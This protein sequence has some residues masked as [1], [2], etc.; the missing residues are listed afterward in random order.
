M[1]PSPPRRRLLQTGLALGAS[2]ALPRARACEFFTTSLRIT[3]PW[4]RA[5]A[6]ADRFAIVNMKFDEVTRTDRLIGV[7]TPVAE[8][9]DM[10]GLLARPTVDFVIPQGQDSA[11][12][13][14]GTFLRLVGLKFPLLP[15]RE[16]P[17]RLVFEQ[18]GAVATTL[19]V[20]YARF[21]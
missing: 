16:F 1:T 11:L 21:K 5:S 12:S 17:L 13:E 3:H 9:A 2:L 7:E 8:G 19:T 4:T 14:S 15:G 20:D 18:A 6:E 10:G